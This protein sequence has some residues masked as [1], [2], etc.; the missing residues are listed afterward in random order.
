MLTLDNCL[1]SFQSLLM[2]QVLHSFEYK[3]LYGHMVVFL[4]AIRTIILVQKINACL[5]NFKVVFS[6]ATV[7][8]YAQKMMYEN[9][10]KKEKKILIATYYNSIYYCQLFVSCQYISHEMVSDNQLICIFLVTMSTFY[11]TLQPFLCILQRSV[12]L[13]IFINLQF[14]IKS[15]QVIYQINVCEYFLQL[16]ASS[17]S[18]SY[19]DFGKSGFHIINNF[20]SLTYYFL[21]P[22]KNF[23]IF[24]VE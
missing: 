23:F 15:S 21:C 10:K 18:C 7:P 11:G 12:F 17:F 2:K 20:C 8:F 24:P 19:A 16:Y 22:T 6:N 13:N 3:P 5:K 1:G 4:W 14:S 9:S